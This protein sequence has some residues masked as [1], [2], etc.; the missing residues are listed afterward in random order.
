M[1]HTQVESAKRSDRKMRELPQIRDTLI[2]VTLLRII[3]FWDLYW[4]PLSRDL[5]I[6]LAFRI[7]EHGLLAA[8]LCARDQDAGLPNYLGLHIGVLE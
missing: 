2:G 8:L 1:L 5:T 6:L 7:P 4:G 3:I